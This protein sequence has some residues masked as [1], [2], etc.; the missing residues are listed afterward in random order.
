M[1]MDNH[2]HYDNDGIHSYPLDSFGLYHNSITY[3][4][5][6][7]HYK[8][9]YY[10]ETIRDLGMRRCGRTFPLSSEK[11]KSEQT[12]RKQRFFLIQ[13]VIP[14]SVK[15]QCVKTYIG[16]F[17]DTMHE[18]EKKYLKYKEVM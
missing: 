11:Q 16:P 1:I 9:K 4:M 15:Y 5:D 14:L 6:I 18:K 17:I 10:K 8:R 13:P 7:T 3:K 12:V 2:M